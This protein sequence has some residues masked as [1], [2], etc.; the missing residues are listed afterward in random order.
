MHLP[1]RIS[2]VCAT[3]LAHAQTTP[4]PS[5][6]DSSVVLDD[7]VVTA[8]PL[9][10][11]QAELTS[12]TSVLT[13]RDLAL[14]QQPTLGETLSAQPG[15]SSTY[16]GPGA[17]RPII[18][19]LGGDR[20]RV[21]Q[22]GTG[23]QDA[24][25][26]SP[27][28]A[29]S[30]EPFLVKRIEVVRGP[31]SLLYGSSAV[32]GV[33]N[34]IDHRIETEMPDRRVSGSIDTRYGTV[35]DEFAYGATTNVAVVKT[36]THAVILH[37]D[38][39]ER[40]AGDVRTP[41]GRLANS[42]V[43]S[44]GG[45][46]GL[47]YV[48]DTFNAGL[49]Y[50]GFNSLYGTV[51]EPDVEI[52]LRQR[53]VDFA[54][55]LKREF[56]IFTGARLKFGTAD[57]EHVE[58]EGGATGTTFTNTGFD[59]RLEL[60]HAPLARFTGAWGV[61][62]VRSDFDIVGAEAFM[63]PALTENHALFVFEETKINTLTWQF[64]ARVERQSIDTRANTNFPAS[65][66]RDDT[67][68]SVSGGVVH[69]INPAYAMAF[70]VTGTERAPN[71]QELYSN[72][73]HIGTA[74]FEI[75]DPSLDTEKSIGVE[76]S[77][78]KLTGLVTGSFNLF[79]NRFDGFIFEEDTG[80][81][82]PGDPFDPDDD[83]PIYQFVQRD[84]L[85]YGA[86]L[87]TFWHLHAGDRHNL[88]LKFNIDYTLA[89]QRNSDD[90]PRI[91]PLKGLIGLAWTGG[92]WSAG[93]DWQLVADQNRTAPGETST[94]GYSLLSAYIGYRLVQGPVVY[95]L[96]MRGSNLTNEEARMHTS[97]L[98]DIAPLPG[99]SVTAGLRASF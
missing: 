94:D 38:G 45:S 6:L 17:S 82:D 60:L 85:F 51:A 10:R 52:D 7:V 92:P 49:N 8:S 69:E 11:S 72:G 54:S 57:Y 14:Q 42:A 16:F 21:L 47:S 83:L 50:N 22:N 73:P 97:F 90:L 24:S 96:F 44:K 74:S 66:S 86:E 77:L 25:I 46:I 30:V 20:I 18:R 40:E 78:R 29:V 9:A 12:A 64:G 87:E 1:F 59:G 33:V 70:S 15:I 53:R 35:A 75:G 28:H 23:T 43:E 39:F 3:S 98:K 2:L 13:G 67:T 71:A 37:L 56:G 19:G 41:A 79:A 89:R 36:D 68:L 63:P 91:P 61:Q 5:A 76:L 55:E 34:V 81:I 32:G 48:S 80:A 93:V 31:A 27:D 65:Q 88:D 26:T 62:A 58:L 84:A 95:D 99:R 4:T